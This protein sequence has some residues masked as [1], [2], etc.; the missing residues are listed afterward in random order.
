MIDEEDEFDAMFAEEMG[1]E[2][3]APKQIGSRNVIEEEKKQPELESL[4]SP[5]VV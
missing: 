2:V 1:E 3:D 5:G 4:E